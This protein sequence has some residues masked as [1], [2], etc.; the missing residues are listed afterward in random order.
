MRLRSGIWPGCSIFLQSLVYLGSGVNHFVNR[1]GYRQIMPDHY[2]HP[3]ALVL[4]TGGAEILGG[5]GLLVP[6]T[7]PAAGYSLALM[8]VCFLDVHV[9]M[10]QHAA[11][12]SS[13]PRWA[14]WARLPFQALLIAWAIAAA[15]RSTVN[16]E[17]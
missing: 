3:E 13:I 10:L 8:L 4:L 9:F 11:R 7:R 12:F 14:L 17:M 16:P 15:R 6:A 5:V 2:A 1:G